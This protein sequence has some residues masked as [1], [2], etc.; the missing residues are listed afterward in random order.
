M[1]RRTVNWPGIS[2]RTESGKKSTPKH[3]KSR[4][5]KF[6]ACALAHIFFAVPHANLLAADERA[7]QIPTAPAH[8]YAYFGRT[9]AR[10]GRLERYA[11]QF[12]RWRGVLGAAPGGRTRVGNGAGGRGSA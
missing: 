12:F 6:P 11:G 7:T 5:G 4:H 10:D 8:A 9:Y 2:R 3:E 1:R